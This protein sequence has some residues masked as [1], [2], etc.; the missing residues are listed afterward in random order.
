MSE[1]D[2]ISARTAMV[3]M[4]VALPILVGMAGMIGYLFGKG[5]GCED[6]V[7]PIRKAALK[8]G[9]DKG[10]RDGWNEVL[11]QIHNGENP[12]YDLTPE[13]GE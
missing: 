6:R 3:F 2:G 8:E 7:E 5:E 4:L 12:Q 9:Y 13:L 11:S 1:K 10:H